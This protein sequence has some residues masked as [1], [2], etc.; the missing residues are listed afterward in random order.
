MEVNVEKTKIRE[1]LR[2]P[3]SIR[4]VIDQKQQENVEYL[5]FWD[6]MVINDA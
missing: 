2:Q 5:K 1:T 6:T 4:I 3:S